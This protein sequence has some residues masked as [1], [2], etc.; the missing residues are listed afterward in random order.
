LLLLL[1]FKWEARDLCSDDGK[2]ADTRSGLVS[3]AEPSSIMLSAVAARKTRLQQAHVP[4]PENRSEKGKLSQKVPPTP[5]P[6]LK[7][8]TKRRYSHQAAVNLSVKKAKKSTLNNHLDFATSSSNVPHQFTSKDD[9]HRDEDPDVSINLDQDDA[10]SVRPECSPVP[11][12][13]G[14]KAWSPSCPIVDSSDD[15]SDTNERSFPDLFSSHNGPLT[16]E[17]PEVLST[18]RP[19][20]EQNLFQLSMNE[21]SALGLNGPAVALLL[22]PSATVSFVGTYQLRVLRGSISL[23]GT[24]VQS[25][26]VLHNVFAPRSSPVPVIQALVACGESSNSLPNIPAR[27]LGAIDDGDVVI[28]LQE[29]Q[30]GIEGLGNVV[31]TFEGDFETNLEGLPDIPL[32][33]IHLVCHSPTKGHIFS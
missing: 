28:L 12:Q 18:Y 8:S 2:V 5:P 26:Q 30:T 33:G 20:R 3:S 27:I 31:R 7:T 21:G 11:T 17:S 24:T 23:L 10:A 15:A 22:S 19:I 4:S 16:S 13:R 25:S 32:E 1:T 9:V 29:L 6:P 14:K